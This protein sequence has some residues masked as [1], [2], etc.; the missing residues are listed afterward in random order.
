MCDRP[1]ANV[2]EMNDALIANWNALISDA[3]EVYILGDLFYKGSGYK[4]NLI[5]RQLKGKKYLIKGNH[6]KY[7]TN[8]HFDVSVFEWVKDY[9]ELIY[10]DARFVLFHFPILEWAH[11]WRKSV[12]LYGHNHRPRK[13]VSENWDRRAINVGVDVNSFFPI[14]AEAV[15]ERGF[16]ESSSDTVNKDDQIE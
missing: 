10:K 15:Y 16:G 11:Y 2:D 14:S 8:P 6:E 13:P 12:H 7:L 3:D 5:F 9:Y 1:F 4:A